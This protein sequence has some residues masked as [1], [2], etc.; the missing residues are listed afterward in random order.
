VG[1]LAAKPRF[2]WR[3][4]NLERRPAAFNFA[5]GLLE[6]LAIVVGFAVTTLCLMACTGGI[7]DDLLL[8]S[9]VA[10][11]VS[12][13][14]PAIVAHRLRPKDDPL[15]ALGLIGETYALLL[16]SFAF[17]FVI[18]AHSRTAPLLA[19]EGDRAARAGARAIARAEWFLARVDPK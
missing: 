16:L 18:L 12:L 14:V 17:A 2:D 4:S 13:A 15:I 19:N 5:H 7:I 1:P 8:R 6:L 11:T 3:E 10:G 9:S